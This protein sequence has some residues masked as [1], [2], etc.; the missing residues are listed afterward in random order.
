[1]PSILQIQKLCFHNLGRAS[2]LL[3]LAICLVSTL[4]AAEPAAKPRLR[5][6]PVVKQAQPASIETTPEIQVTAATAPAAHKP[7]VRAASLTLFQDEPPIPAAAP[8]VAP[9]VE[10]AQ[11]MAP[12]IMEEPISPSDTAPPKPQ[13][14]QSIANDR[15][16]LSGKPESFFESLTPEDRIIL[17]D[18]KLAD[19]FGIGRT[20]DYKVDGKE[21]A[22]P[23]NIAAK[24]F[25]QEPEENFPNGYHHDWYPMVAMWEA[26]AFYHRPLYFEEVNLE[27]YGHTHKHL[28]PVY[29]AAHFFGNTLALPY[30]M[31][32]YPPCER[33]YT[34]G[35]YRP[36][37]C[38]P[39]D[40]HTTPFTWKGV[41][42]TGAVYSGIGAAFP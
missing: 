16:R 24:V 5:I 41:V 8:A 17:Y 22:P 3:I 7:V 39:H 4:S 23:T 27:R 35:H 13:T 31:G 29:S 42:Y 20:N 15:G 30:K 25:S 1:M 26:P 28:Q 34:L 14:L 18:G 36:G 10:D 11:P 32:A 6:Q 9:M 2:M 37:D 21:I 33:I 38:N 19:Q 40:I 12:P